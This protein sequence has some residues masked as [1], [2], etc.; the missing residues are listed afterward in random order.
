MKG[1]KAQKRVGLRNDRRRLPCRGPCFHVCVAGLQIRWENF[2]DVTCTSRWCCAHCS[3][4]T[5][6]VCQDAGHVHNLT[7]CDLNPACQCGYLSSVA[8]GRKQ[9]GETPR[10][11]GGGVVR[12]SFICRST[13]PK[14]QCCMLCT[15]QA[16][17]LL[18]SH[19]LVLPFQ[20]CMWG[21]LF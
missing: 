17:C 1:S 6:R 21:L 2:A 7:C 5:F 13:M 18:I 8:Q 4:E 3:A 16:V 11:G 9:G 15:C 19:H 20:Q 10:G 14:F 12:S